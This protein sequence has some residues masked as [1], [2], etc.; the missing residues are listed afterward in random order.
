MGRQAGAPDGSSSACVVPLGHT[1]LGYASSQQRLP[2]KLP[3]SSVAVAKEAGPL[4]QGTA[5]ATLVTGHNTDLDYRHCARGLGAPQ[6]LFRARVVDCWQ[7]RHPAVGDSGSQRKHRGV[8]AAAVRLR[9][10]GDVS[11]AL[12]AISC[13]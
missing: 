8:G 7:T 3:G 12:C 9:T 6:V 4:P 1:A 2:P 5:H 10:R 13:L 11:R